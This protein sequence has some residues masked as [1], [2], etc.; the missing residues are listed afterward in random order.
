MNSSIEGPAGRSGAEQN[1]SVFGTCPLGALQRQVRRLGR[2]RRAGILERDRAWAPSLTSL[3]LVVVSARVAV[4][5]CSV[6]G[7]SGLDVTASR[8]PASR[9]GS[10]RPACCRGGRR[11]GWQP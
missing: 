2:S 8:L 10:A 6:M 7:A 9:S 5:P 1:H 4:V 11:G 3:Q